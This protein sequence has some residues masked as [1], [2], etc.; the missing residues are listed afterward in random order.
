[1]PWPTLVRRRIPIDVRNRDI[2]VTETMICTGVRS[3]LSGKLRVPTRPTFAWSNGYARPV[4]P[5]ICPILRITLDKEGFKL[6]DLST[7]CKK[8]RKKTCI[9]AIHVAGPAAG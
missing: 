6:T 9:S 5:P 1:M 4:R 2:Q 7:A 8:K 3:A